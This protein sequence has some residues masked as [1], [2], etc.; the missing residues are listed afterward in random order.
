[1]ANNT[2]RRA[3]PMGGFLRT[4][5]PTFLTFA[6]LVG[7]AYLTWQVVQNAPAGTVSRGVTV[8]RAVTPYVLGWE[9]LGQR[10]GPRSAESQHLQV[11][12]TDDAWAFTNIANRRRVLMTTADGD[13]RFIHRWELKEGDRISFNEA[14]IEVVGVRSDR[15]TLREKNSKR[16]FTWDG[17]PHPKGE[18][19]TR[20][21]ES[22]LRRALNGAKWMTR[23]WFANVENEVRVFTIGGGVNCSN[24]WMMPA[25]PPGAVGITWENGSFWVAPGGLRAETLL[26]REGSSRGTAFS[27]LVFPYD[28]RFGRVVSTI[29]GITRYLIRADKD[30]MRFIPIANRDFFL[31]TSTPPRNPVAWSW[32]GDGNDFVTWA[33]AR[34]VF[35]G[36]GVGLATFLC[37]LIFWAGRKW[38]PYSA[39]WTLQTIVG[40]V[41]AA[42]GIWVTLLLSQGAGRP[43]QS[44]MV[45]AA[46]IAWLWA[47]FMMVWS[48][49][50]QGF[51]AWLWLC[52]V[53][54]AT[55]GTTT[56][57]QLG[58]GAE[59]TRWLG[60]YY[61]HAAILSLF[62]WTMCA[63]VLVPD[64]WW[65]R[66]WLNIF[67]R[68]GLVALAAIVLI[69]AMGLQF[70]LGSEEGL[71]GLQPVEIVKTVFVILLGY[72]GMHIAEA[73]QREV[74]AFRQAPLAFMA[75]YFRFAG[76]FFLF[77]ASVVVGVRDFS[78][79]VI[80]TVVLVAWLWRIGGAQAQFSRA[81]RFFLAI[82][83]VILLGVVGILALMYYV[84]Q[85]P[86]I[87][88]DGF[89]QKDR[90]QVW[91]Q[92]QLHPHSGSQVLGSM[93]FVGQGGWF[94]ARAW[95]GANGPV[96][97]LPAVQDDFIT[98]FLINRFGG[99]AGLALLFVELFY[100][101]LLFLLGRSVERRF[102]RGDFGEQNAGIVL[103]YTLYGLA[104][105]HIA[106]WLISWGNTLGLLPV[107]GQPMTWLTAGNSHLI[108]F[109]LL[110]GF[111]A[112]VTGWINNAY[113]A[114]EL[115]S[116][117]VRR[118]G[119][120][121]GAERGKA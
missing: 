17:S 104:W 32:L 120:V 12:N 117:R 23:A 52:L 15:L 6:I 53:A 44:L 115:P 107:M 73:R 29:V 77:I 79:M 56:L 99:L 40:L 75:P 62:G 31:A 83:P 45:V 24:R 42:L 20:V 5:V 27:Q 116:R 66:I 41:P 118:A 110:I 119:P 121:L 35:L 86:D 54:L 101:L 59:N 105:M 7:W 25:L 96:M 100:V 55:I 46:W 68:E 30:Q 67:N 108:G 74:R 81:G 50:M 43:D 95:Y 36:I 78:P 93:D 98:A 106:H 58:A 63:L 48:G 4:V 87:V 91:A 114:E 3:N 11:R 18:K 8:A 34:I 28:G 21:C 39:M 112:L 84:Y 61:K 33:R 19:V 26:F 90:I 113:V 94:G 57:F 10:P 60:F 49:R 69:G 13:S 37:V 71:A 64:P 103:G 1:M 9:E 22:I 109:A 72:V 38:H 111:V 47:T 2:R 65:R 82:R 14:E 97:T 88:P 51:P 102:A 92:P 85:N 76:I 16:E 80:M 70:L 89:P